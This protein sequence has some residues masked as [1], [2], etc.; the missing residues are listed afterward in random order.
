MRIARDT[1]LKVCGYY[2]ATNYWTSRAQIGDKMKEALNIEIKKAHATIVNFQI[3]K[4]VLPAQYEDSIVQ[5]Q[6]EVQKSNMRKFEQTAE[7]TRQGIGVLDSQAKQLIKV[8][9]ATAHAEAYKI[10]QFAQVMII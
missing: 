6:V 4:V 1:I 7:L 8:I 9:N 2:N 3:L 5:T 10:E